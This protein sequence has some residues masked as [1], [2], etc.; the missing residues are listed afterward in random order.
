MIR[1]LM[2]YPIDYLVSR[3]YNRLEPQLSAAETDRQIIKLLLGRLLSNS[4]AT[5]SHAKLSDT[6][7]KIFS[8]WG[9]DGIIQYLIAAL[10]PLPNIFIEFGVADYW[11]ANTRFLLLN[12]NWSGLVMDGSAENIKRIK[13]DAIHWMYDL[14]ARRC[15]VTRENINSIITEAGFSGDIGLL[16][17]DIDGMDYWVWSELDCVSPVIAIVEYNSL[18]GPDRSITVPYESHFERFEA[19]RSGLYAGASLA[20]LVDLADEKGYSFIGSNS[21]GNN[22]YFVRR[23]R[24]DRLRP[25]TAAE[26]YVQSKFREHRDNDGRLTFLTGKEAVSCLAGMPVVNTKTGSLEAL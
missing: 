23:D 16:H 2:N 7:F 10:D 17:I 14:T 18:F 25:V 21:S 8:Q 22:A 12:N 9:D 5:G 1:S 13:N 15:F 11:E 19:H 4:I 20:A 24:V 6:E 26:G 3:I